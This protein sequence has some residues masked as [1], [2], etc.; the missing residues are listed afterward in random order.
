MLFILKCVQYPKLVISSDPIIVVVCLDSYV[1]WKFC[2]KRLL[3][4]TNWDQKQFPCR[5]VK[6]PDLSTKWQFQWFPVLCKIPPNY[7]LLCGAELP[8][9][10]SSSGISDSPFLVMQQSRHRSILRKFVYSSMFDSN[11]IS[12]ENWWEYSF[13]FTLLSAVLTTPLNSKCDWFSRAKPLATISWYLLKVHQKHIYFF[14]LSLPIKTLGYFIWNNGLVD[15]GSS[16]I[17]QNGIKNIFVLKSMVIFVSLIHECFAS[18]GF[19]ASAI[20]KRWNY[21]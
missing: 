10:S 21:W 20:L 4:D 14:T 5:F 3:Y 16:I 18:P 6:Q 13:P 7:E 1:I 9:V 2:N 19:T 15:S 17:L 12:C 11:F 8:E